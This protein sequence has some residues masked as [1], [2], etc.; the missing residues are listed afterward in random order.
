MAEEACFS[1]SGMHLK[2]TKVFSVE[3]NA[4]AVIG[5]FCA[6]PNPLSIEVEPFWITGTNRTGNRSSWEI[7]V[8]AFSVGKGGSRGIG[9]RGGDERV[10]P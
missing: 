5:F 10:V 7:R 1:G 9:L 8:E 6:R 2:R 4:V 3:P